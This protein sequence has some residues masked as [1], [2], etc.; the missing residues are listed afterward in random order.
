MDSV[1]VA[2]VSAANVSAQVSSIPM[3]N[4]TNFKVWKD[5]VEIFLSCM[6]L[7]ITLQQDKPITT[8]KNANK[9][10]IEK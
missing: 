7:D 2:S 4:C 3:L 10:K 8:E 1:G 9:A 5:T 6:D